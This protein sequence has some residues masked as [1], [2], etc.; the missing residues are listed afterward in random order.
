MKLSSSQDYRDKN[1]TSGTDM[2]TQKKNLL[3]TLCLKSEQKIPTINCIAYCIHVNLGSNQSD[4]NNG[5]TKT[6]IQQ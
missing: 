2:A 3:A 1:V 6:M 5:I 4:H